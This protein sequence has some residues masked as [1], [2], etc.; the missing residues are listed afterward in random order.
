MSAT[1]PQDGFGW[2][3]AV[4]GAD[5][6]WRSVDVGGVSTRVFR[7]AAA[8]GRWLVWA[9]GGSWIGGSVEGW[10][11]QCADLAHWTGCTVV[12][13]DY[14]LAP[15]HPHPAALRDVLTVL[16]WAAGLG[17]EVAVGG[18]SAGGTIAACAALTWRDLGYSLS[19]QLLAYPPLDPRCEAPSYRRPGVIPGR[20]HLLTAWRLYLRD[21][22][23]GEHISPLAA[24]ELRGIAPALIAVGANDPVIDD[25]RAYTRRIRDAGGSACLRVFPATGHGAFLESGPSPLRR[26]FGTAYRELLR[27]RAATS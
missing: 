16:D 17:M 14:R 1:R 15:A 23:R 4:G 5:V 19:A 3:E 12:A 20:D 8:G 27:A 11:L 22:D 24:R 2:R 7:P 21:G 18:D 13:V 9:H 6:H 25:V 26:W 10:H